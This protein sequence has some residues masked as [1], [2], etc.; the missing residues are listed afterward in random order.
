[1]DYI[2][3]NGKQKACREGGSGG[4][5]QPLINKEDGVFK[6]VCCSLMYSVKIVLN[7]YKFAL[8]RL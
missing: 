5:G 1:M 4:N 8:C 7:G 6:R 3:S 2:E